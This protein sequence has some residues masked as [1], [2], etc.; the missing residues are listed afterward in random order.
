MKQYSV[1]MDL[2]LISGDGSKGHYLLQHAD[3]RQVGQQGYLRHHRHLTSTSDI[4]SSS[5][6]LDWPWSD[7]QPEG[8]RESGRH[9]SGRQ[10]EVVCCPPEL[11]SR[12][13]GS[14]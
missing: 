6:A 2:I 13:I 3:S 8:R 9:E 14:S 11:V 1:A 7:L 4:A 10:A 5:S 12:S